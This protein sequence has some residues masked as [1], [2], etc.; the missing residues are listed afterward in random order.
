[1]SERVLVTVDGETVE[2]RPATVAEIAPLR[3]AILRAGL[4]PEEAFFAGDERADSFHYGGFHGG[5]PVACATMHASTW[6]ERPAFQ[7]RGMATT[8]RF[9]GRGLGR[10]L[11]EALERDI[12]AAAPTVRQLW[13]NARTPAI[14]F[15][16]RLGWRVV[17]AV[18]EIPTAGPHVRMTKAF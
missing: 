16:E 9:R 12:R 10:V 13:C 2:V 4:P 1:M 3:H 7:L 17:S 5:Q 11:L 18:F 14:G 8:A 6:D 15:Y